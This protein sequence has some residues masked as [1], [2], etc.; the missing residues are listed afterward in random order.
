[1]PK[2]IVKEVMVVVVVVV[3]LFPPFRL[4]PLAIAGP[5]RSRGGFL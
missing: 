5:F 4:C 2:C 1:M 3:L